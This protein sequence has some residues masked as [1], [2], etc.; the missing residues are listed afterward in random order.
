MCG[1]G[2]RESSTKQNASS[3]MSTYL[4]KCCFIEEVSQIQK[5]GG[6]I[7]PDK[8]VTRKEKYT[9]ISLININERD[10]NARLANWYI[11]K[12]IHHNQVEFIPE[13]H[14]GFNTQKLIN[15]T[16]YTNETKDKTTWY[17]H[18]LASVSTWQNPVILHDKNSQQNR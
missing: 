14:S 1:N 12:I 18:Y 11:K 4:L 9:P 10:L 5:N 15:I 8:S 6:I 7:K 3:G 2:T 13:M 17:L 16:H